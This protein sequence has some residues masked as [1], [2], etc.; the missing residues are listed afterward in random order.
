[1][2]AFLAGASL[3][4]M[5]PLTFLTGSTH[6]TGTIKIILSGTETLHVVR[7]GSPDGRGGIVLEQSSRQGNKP[8]ILRRLELRPTSAI[9]LTGTLT[10]DATG[11]VRGSES[12]NALSLVYSLKGGLAAVQTLILQ[13]GNR[14]LLNRVIIKK[15]G[16]TVATIEEA[17]TK[18]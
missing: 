1:M 13:P 17:I 9:T 6:G 7:H 11:P 2:I 10:P 14:V 16:L 18:D 15:F 5:S 8:A 3:A 4:A 12:G